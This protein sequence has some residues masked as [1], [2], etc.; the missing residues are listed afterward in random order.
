MK[1]EILIR[2][3]LLSWFRPDEVTDYNISAKRPLTDKNFSAFISLFKDEFGGQQ[4]DEDEKE[5]L[6]EII[7]KPLIFGAGYPINEKEAIKT[8][9][10]YFI[11]AGW[12]QTSS[13]LGDNF[14]EGRSG[15]HIAVVGTTA[16]STLNMAE[17]SLLLQVVTALLL[18]GRNYF[19]SFHMSNPMVTETLY[20]MDEAQSME[21]GF[22]IRTL[23]MTYDSKRHGVITNG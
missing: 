9:S 18:S 3:W 1:P 2:D 13:Y 22:S 23:T 6:K 15:T 10:I 5:T 12:Q 8:G 16:G 7:L 14:W 11:G 21:K 19:T 20:S 17:T 4:F